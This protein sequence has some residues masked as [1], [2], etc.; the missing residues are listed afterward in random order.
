[1]RFGPNS[2]SINSAQ[3]LRDIYGFRANVRKAEFYDAFAHPLPNTH[4]TRDRE[5][6][7]DA[8]RKGVTVVEWAI[9]ID[10]LKAL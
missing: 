4:N 9:L 7:E 10:R 3:A 5:V 6:R 2:V 8:L 1:M